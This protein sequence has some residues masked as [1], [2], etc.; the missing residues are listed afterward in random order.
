MDRMKAAVWP[1]GRKPDH[2][3]RQAQSSSDH[4]KVA[5]LIKFYPALVYGGGK[6][7]QIVG[8]DEKAGDVRACEWIR[9]FSA[10]AGADG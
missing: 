5:E 4:D 3:R 7:V 2:R 10:H 1:A 9:L 6:D 8:R